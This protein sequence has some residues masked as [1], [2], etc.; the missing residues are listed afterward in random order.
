M[1][2][3]APAATDAVPPLEPRREALETIAAQV[4]A[5]DE[6]VGLARR[7]IQVFDIDLSEMGWNGRERSDRLAGFL[8]RSRLARLDIIVHDT[9]YIESRCAR[10]TALQRLFAEAITIRRT[11]PEARG[12]MD[13][14]V[15]VDGQHYLHR[16]HID[17]P[18]ATLGILQPQAATPLIERFREIWATGETSGQG[19]VLGL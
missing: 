11:G 4:A 19:T 1:A 18:R 3:S 13:P 12:A 9:R 2:T 10:L 17:R 15:I 16:Y 6:L 5:I 14:L 7:S 8:R